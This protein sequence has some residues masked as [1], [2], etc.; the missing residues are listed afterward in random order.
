[1][2]DLANTT[3]ESELLLLCAR[4]SSDAVVAARIRACLANDIDWTRLVTWS[5]R[6]EVTGL[7]YGTLRRVAATQTPPEI[8]EAME[9]HCAEL[10]VR[11][12]QLSDELVHVVSAL[13]DAGIDPITFKGPTLAA[14]LYGELYKRPFRDLDLL[15]H[16]QEVDTTVAVL[17]GLGY[18]LQSSLTGAQ[19]QCFRNYSGQYQLR[20][21]GK[22]VCIEPHWT[23]AQAMMSID[24]D[25]RGLRQRSV[26]TTLGAAELKTFAIEDIALLLCVHGG[27]EQWTSLKWIC[28]LAEL[29]RTQPGLDWDT[30]SSRAARHGCARMLLLGVTLA[31]RLLDAPVPSQLAAKA[32]ADRYV[33][34][35]AREVSQSLFEESSGVPSIWRVNRFRLRMRERARDKIRY[36][37]RTSFTPWVQ[38]FEMV[39]LPDRLFKGYYLVRIVHDYLLL[40]LW[41]MVKRW[42]GQDSAAEHDLATVQA[43]DTSEPTR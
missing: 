15:I 12:Q 32:C 21:A 42:R 11:L 20:H 37:L 18:E 40:P 4:T 5:L 2:S 19:Q 24:F 8:L 10:D 9:I 23:L 30:V 13:H 31:E 7:V 3:L 36:V 25:Y 39:R 27:K 17:A 28:D 43:D 33:D 35:L 34:G 26:R 29:V 14:H 38:H 1:M 6:H 16:E 22:R 41:Q